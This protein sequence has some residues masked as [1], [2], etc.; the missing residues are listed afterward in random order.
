ME[1]RQ[2]TIEV[3][4]EFHR[5]TAAIIAAVQAGMWN[6]GVHD[7]LGYATDFAVGEARGRQTLVLKS[8]SRSSYMRLQWESILGDG[9]ADRQLVDDAIQSAIN[10]LA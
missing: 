8:R 4:L 7:L 9:A 3:A 6:N 5:R 1:N 2:F 10:E